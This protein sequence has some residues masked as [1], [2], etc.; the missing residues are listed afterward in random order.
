MNPKQPLALRCRRRQSTQLLKHSLSSFFFF[1]FSLQLV[2]PSST[3][4][5]LLQAAGGVK[6]VL[7]SEMVHVFSDALPSLFQ[8]QISCP[9]LRY[10]LIWIPINVT[11]LS[12]TVLFECTVFMGH[13]FKKHLAAVP[14]ILVCG[15]VTC[16]LFYHPHRIS[17]KSSVTS[18]RRKIRRN[19]K[20][21]KR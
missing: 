12:I 10:S 18:W 14:V 9:V 1:F 16:F 19:G 8:H 5:C 2:L 13:D 3:N 17:F 21:R 20:M 15:C 7:L 11:T 4:K 6:G